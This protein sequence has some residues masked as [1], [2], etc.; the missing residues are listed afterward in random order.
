MDGRDQEFFFQFL[1]KKIKN[2][3]QHFWKKKVFAK[4][5]VEIPT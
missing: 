2:S 3:K 4:Y 5:M 1:N